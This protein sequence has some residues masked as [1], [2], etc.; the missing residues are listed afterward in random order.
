MDLSALGLA[1]LAPI[2]RIPK[3][4]KAANGGDVEALG[5]LILAQE[6]G[7][8]MAQETL[9]GGATGMARIIPPALVALITANILALGWAIQLLF[10]LSN[11][12]AAIQANR[13]TVQDWAR[14]YALIDGRLDKTVAKERYEREM[15]AARERI[16]VLEAR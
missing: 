2:H 1:L 16:R 14:S 10:A 12:V 5:N 11:N 4:L 9:N 7:D 6:D 8:P 15:T 3:H 13:F